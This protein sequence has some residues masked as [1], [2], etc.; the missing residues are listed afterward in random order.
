M[1]LSSQHILYASGLSPCSSVLL[2]RLSLVKTLT[3][4]VTVQHNGHCQLIFSILLVTVVDT[5]TESDYSNDQV[6]HVQRIKRCKDYYEVLQVSKDASEMDLKK[7]YRKLALQLHPDKNKAPGAA[8]AFK[9]V[10]NAFAVL[11]DK[12]KRRQYDMYG[13]EDSM[14]SQSASSSAR[15]GYY[16]GGDGYYYDYSRGFEGNT[17]LHSCSSKKC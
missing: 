8:E 11:N 9:A 14:S 10:G 15:S 7:N 13:S 4:R 12:D 2:L 3:L 6:V 1:S 17:R 16:D 5:M